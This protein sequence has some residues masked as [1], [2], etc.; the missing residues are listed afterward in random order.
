MKYTDLSEKQLFKLLELRLYN[1]PKRQKPNSVEI[2]Q[3]GVVYSDVQNAFGVS[4]I[5]HFKDYQSE[6]IIIIFNK[7]YPNEVF[8]LEKI[9]I[10]FDKTEL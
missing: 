5:Q 2:E 1:E 7:F 9:G 3:G 4:F 8:Y 10:E 6:R